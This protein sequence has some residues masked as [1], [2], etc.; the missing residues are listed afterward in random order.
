MA[1]DSL[2]R[3]DFYQ[4]IGSYNALVVGHNNPTLHQLR[5]ALKSIGVANVTP[6]ESY[7]AALVGTQ[8]GKIT[9]AVFDTKESDIPAQTFVE[10]MIKIRKDIVLIALS[11]DPAVDN[12]FDL[13][14]A[15]ARGFIVPPPTLASVESV[16]I[17]ATNGPPFSESILRA[18]D[19][20]QVFADLVLD[21]LYRAALLKRRSLDDSAA[22]PLFERAWR[23]L[24]GTMDM[25]KMFCEHSQDHLT[26]S[27]VHSCMRRADDENKSRLGKVRSN[28]TKKRSETRV[29]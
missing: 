28:L 14:R 27:I 19:R 20:N 29:D 24:V 11:S 9:H 15:G 4:R 25:S 3:R 2:A 8:S 6:A 5:T 10:A 12:V 21:L 1:Q 18:K 22:A 13:I 26:R 7:S 17:A 16:L 23:A